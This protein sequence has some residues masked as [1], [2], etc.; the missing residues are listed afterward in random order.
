[1]R[2]ASVA[3]LNSVCAWRAHLVDDPAQPRIELV[4]VDPS[5]GLADV[6]GEIGGAF[7]LGDD[8]HRRDDSSKVAG[9]WR[10]QGEQ[11]VAGLVELE[12]LG[13]DLVVGE[14]HQLG[15]LEVLGEED[16][17]RPR[18]ALGHPGGELGDALAKLVELVVERPAQVAASSGAAMLSSGNSAAL[19]R[20]SR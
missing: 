4:A 2:Y 11:L 3:S 19:I 6:D 5:R 7:D 15:A 20:T 10:L 18:D 1:M 9:D 13:V 16:L 17:R 12:R 14:D 8:A